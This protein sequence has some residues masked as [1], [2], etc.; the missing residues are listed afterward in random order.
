MSEIRINSTTAFAFLV[1]T[2]AAVFFGAYAYGR[3]RSPESSTTE[4]PSASAAVAGNVFVGRIVGFDPPSV[5]VRSIWDREETTRAI[6][7]DPHTRILKLVPWGPGERD[8]TIRAFK[9]RVEELG[10]KKGD[11]VPSPPSEL[12][13]MPMPAASLVVGLEVAVA[14]DASSDAGSPLSAMLIRPLTEKEITEKGLS[15]TFPY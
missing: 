13:P 9:E 6:I 2:A 5:L 7:V 11:R 14:L 1:L 4:V 10:L 12:K 8:E 15:V 3:S